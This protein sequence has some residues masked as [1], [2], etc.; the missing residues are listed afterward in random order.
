MRC[1]PACR[2][3][4]EI[5]VIPFSSASHTHVRTFS[6]RQMS[7]YIRTYSPLSVQQL[8]SNWGKAG[9][10]VASADFR[11]LT[12]RNSD[13][14]CRGRRRLRAKVVHSLKEVPYSFKRLD[15]HFSCPWL[16]PYPPVKF[17]RMEQ[18][19]FALLTRYILYEPTLR[20]V[21]CT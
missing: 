15:L 20:P 14:T 12:I 1:L 9:R 17:R 11:I 2:K 13:N 10:G 21:M 19:N 18:F 3:L 7:V 16:R 6:L 8:L 5:L 4:I